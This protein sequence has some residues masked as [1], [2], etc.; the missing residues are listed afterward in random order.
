MVAHG[1]DVLST[2]TPAATAPLGE[3]LAWLEAGR[4]EHI[5]LGLERCA[6]VAK[7]LHW[8]VLHRWW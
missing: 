6:E 2:L 7:R 1:S 8:R 4:G 5:D 3:W